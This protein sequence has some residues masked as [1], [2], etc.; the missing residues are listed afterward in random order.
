VLLPVLRTTS[1]PSPTTGVSVSDS[2]STSTSSCPPTTGG[3]P[4]TKLCSIVKINNV[5]NYVRGETY[6]TFAM[7]GTSSATLNEPLW[8]A[9]KYG[10]FKYTKEDQTAANGTNFY[11]T[12]LNQ[13]DR[14]KETGAP[15]L[16]TEADPCDGV[17][18]NY[19]YARRPDLLSNSL[20]EILE[21]I[22][23]SSNTA[24]AIASSQLQEGDL[25]VVAT[26]D[27]G[28]GSGALRSYA[29]SD[30]GT[31]A[32]VGNETWNAHT[33]LTQTAASERQ[34]ITNQP[35]SGVSTGV[36]FTW[37]SLT[38]SH[39]GTFVEIMRSPFFWLTSFLSRRPTTTPGRTSRR[40]TTQR[41]TRHPRRR[42][43]PRRRPSSP[44]RLGPKKWPATCGRQCCPTR[45]G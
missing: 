12:R 33:L 6:K 38:S 42:R 35:V 34:V 14:K 30:D 24:P 39:L 25:K 32:A 21:D 2:A 4:S 23:T 9:A 37:A 18:D 28:D 31:F 44:P 13:W 26:F 1:S 5:D 29:L 11:P 22:V 27:A 40:R 19:F 3:S 17:P 43:R 36:A 41:T 45:R 15:C 20:R 16:G 7:R 8:Y 10:G